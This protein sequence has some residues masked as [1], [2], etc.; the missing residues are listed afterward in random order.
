MNATYITSHNGSMQFA[1]PGYAQRV[2][3]VAFQQDW[4]WWSK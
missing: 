3:S 1:P 4:T 2:S